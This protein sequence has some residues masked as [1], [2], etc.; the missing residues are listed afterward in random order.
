MKHFFTFLLISLTTLSIHAQVRKRCGNKEIQ[1]RIQQHPDY[2]NHLLEKEKLIKNFSF[3]KMDTVI[4]IPVVVHVIWRTTSENISNQQI[5]SQIDVLNLDYRKRNPDTTN[6]VSGFSKSD[7]KIEFVLAVLDPDGNT[8][9]G[10]TRTQTN[11][12]DIGNTSQY[13]N[14]VPA[15]NSRRYLNIW[16]CDVGDF[17]LGFAYPPNTPGVS[18]QEDGLVIGSQYFG[19]T[20]SVVAPY[21]LGRTTTHEIGHYFDLL[22]PWGNDRNPSC[23]SDDMITDTPNQGVEIYDCPNTHTSCG[24][25]DMLSNFMGYIDDGCMGN[26]TLGQKERMRMALYT[27]RDS[28]QYAE[29]LGLVSVREIDYLQKTQIYPNPS[30]R[31]FNFVFSDKVNTQDV[32]LEVYDITGR[33]ISFRTKGIVNGYAIELIDASKG[34]YFAKIKTGEIAVTKKLIK[35]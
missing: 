8:T 3:N 11:V 32:K 14:L 1:A 10:I 35:P 16:V 24:S 27:Q 18:L 21:N 19:T 20:G 17:L 4:Y 30:N 15:W 25:A 12:D 34:V 6:V 13:Y 28:L 22:H 2:E 26:F 33:S 29:A 5:Q 23:S 7:V 31:E 9:N